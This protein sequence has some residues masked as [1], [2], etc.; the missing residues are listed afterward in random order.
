MDPPHRVIISSSANKKNFNQWARWPTRPIFV[1][2]TSYRCIEKAHLQFVEPTQVTGTLK[3]PI[4]NSSNPHKL[5]V[6]WK[7][8]SYVYM[9]G[10][11]HAWIEL[12]RD[13]S[14]LT[15]RNILPK[16][17]G[18]L[19]MYD[20]D[21]VEKTKLIDWVRVEFGCHSQFE[22]RGTRTKEAPEKNWNCWNLCLSD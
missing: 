15:E 6:H 14:M 2:P 22:V 10:Q 21:F 19:G 7:S 17:V 8:P 9:P 1:P 16:S 13:E 18:I 5:Q 20:R 4:F 12:A 11:V 3:K